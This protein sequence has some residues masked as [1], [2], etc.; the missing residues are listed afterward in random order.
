MVNGVSY[1]GEEGT[2]KP[3]F[4]RAVTDN[5]MGAGLSTKYQAWRN[6]ALKLIDMKVKQLKGK[7]KKIQVV[8][9]T[10]DMPEV[11]AQ[12]IVDYAI[13]P[14][15][16]MR[17]EQKL[18]TTQGANVPNMLRFGM[19]MQLPYDMEQSEFFGRGPIENYADRKF[20]QRFGIYQQAADEQFYPYIRP[21]ETGTKSDMRWWKQTNKRGIGLLVRS[22][23]PFSASALHYTVEDLDDGVAKE[24]RHVQQVPKSLFT[25][26]Y[27]N[28][29]M[30]GVGGVD[31]WSAK[32]EALE[33]YR[34]VY[35]DKAFRFTLLPVGR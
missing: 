33:A 16:E 3:C 5:D 13:Y 22:D 14:S 20:S 18:Q 10:Y 30:A 35:G 34:V 21:Q 1:L 17:I 24:Q 31:S 2:L 19:V 23:K 27:I 4:W 32:A 9:S 26:L 28:S 8:T 12:L 7:D 6:P 11:K 15:G 29:E 25:N